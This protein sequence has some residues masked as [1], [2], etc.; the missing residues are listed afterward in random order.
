[1]DLLPLSAEIKTFF[2]FIGD[3]NLKSMFWVFTFEDY[4]SGDDF[5]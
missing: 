5:P 1:M 3:V 2:F 4:S